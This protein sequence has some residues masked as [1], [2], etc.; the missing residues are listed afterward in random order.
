MSLVEKFS[1][2]FGDRKEEV[3]TTP[4]LENKYSPK[5]VDKGTGKLEYMKEEVVTIC[6]KDLY[7]FQGQSKV[8]T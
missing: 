1:N 8:S 5:D 2:V 3:V 7:K 4:F 6:W